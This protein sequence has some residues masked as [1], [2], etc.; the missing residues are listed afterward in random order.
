MCK[1]P[2]TTLRGVGPSPRGSC[3]AAG[4]GYI[5]KGTLASVPQPLLVHPHAQGPHTLA[6][7]GTPPHGSCFAVGRGYIK[8]KRSVRHSKNNAT[9]RE[10]RAVAFLFCKKRPRTR[11]GGYACIKRAAEATQRPSAPP[12][13][14]IGQLGRQ[15]TRRAKSGVKGGKRREK[16]LHDFA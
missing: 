10:N 9:T 12:C 1:V 7:V 15:E 13:G 11:C 6:R 5:F 3:F 8:R 4:R 2:P 16:A 14:A